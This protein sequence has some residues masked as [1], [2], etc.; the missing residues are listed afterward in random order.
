MGSLMHHGLRALR[1][2]VAGPLSHATGILA[3]FD[4]SDGD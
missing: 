1:A 3:G 2:L 4:A